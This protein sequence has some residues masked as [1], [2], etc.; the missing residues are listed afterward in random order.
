VTVDI[1]MD[2]VLEL[3]RQLKESHKETMIGVTDMLVKACAIALT[4]HEDINSYFQDNKLL[5]H[6]S[7]NV[8]VAVALE[9]GLIV[10]V[11]KDADKKSLV[12]ISR[13]LKDL[14]DRSR[15]GN[16]RP[17]EYSGGTFTISNLGMFD[18]DS[19]QAIVVP[20]E[21]A[22]LAVGTA[23]PKAI[24]EDDQIKVAHI[25]KATLSADHRITDGAGAARFLQTLKQ[26][27]QTPLRLME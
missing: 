21:A 18:V 20:P 27:L 14:V 26:I 24:V 25:M 22:I 1:N 3:H 11:V 4:E 17:D 16:I 23:Y 19:F 5:R 2:R 6:S 9:N 13:E 12:Q 8:G 10:P 7:A 15:N